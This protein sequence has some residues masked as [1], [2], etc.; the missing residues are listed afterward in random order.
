MSLSNV[1]VRRLERYSAQRVVVKILRQIS[2]PV[3]R[4][5]LCDRRKG[6]RLRQE[7][8]RPPVDDLALDLHRFDAFR[9]FRRF[10]HQ[11]EASVGPLPDQE[12]SDG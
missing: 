3:V 7:V 5:H 9:Q 8:Q 6:P 12:R 11:R 1:F 2:C 4:N 10:E